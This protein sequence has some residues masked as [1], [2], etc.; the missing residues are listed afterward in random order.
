[1]LPGR[2]DSCWANFYLNEHKYLLEGNL[3]SP[4]HQAIINWTTL[5]KFF[6]PLVPYSCQFHLYRTK[7]AGNTL[8]A[9]VWEDLEFG[10]TCWTPSLFAWQNDIWNITE[11]KVDD[12][13]VFKLCSAHLAVPEY[14][15]WMMADT[16]PKILAYIRA[17]NEPCYI[18]KK[19][20]ITK[21]MLEGL[22]ERR[23]FQF[24]YF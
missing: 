9:S 20:I 7:H 3:G 23:A 11:K 21:I 2:L 12:D 1:M 24:K 17:R 14:S 10:K 6:L 8:Q 16:L 18:E 22:K 5:E 19:N 13:E 4:K 15:L